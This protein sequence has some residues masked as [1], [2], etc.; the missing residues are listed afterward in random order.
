ME[1]C[2]DYVAFLVNNGDFSKVNGVVRELNAFPACFV[3]ARKNVLHFKTP[4]KMNLKEKPG[5]N[6]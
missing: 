1:L 6:D 4:N 3:D 2:Y 5:Q